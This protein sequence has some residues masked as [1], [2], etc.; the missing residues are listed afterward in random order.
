MAKEEINH[1]TEYIKEIYKK[2]NP[3]ENVL[4]PENISIEQKPKKSKKLFKAFLIFL[5]ITVIGISSF[6]GFGLAVFS[7]FMLF[8][9]LLTLMPGDKFL[10]PT[11]VL[12]L[13]EDSAGY[14][15]RSDTIMVAHIDPKHNTIGVISIPRDSRVFIPGH[16]EDKVNHAFAFG[17]IE[18][19]KQTIEQFLGIKIPYYIVIDI[20]GLRN[21]I[22]DLGGITIN[23]EKR[24]YYIDYS[25]NLFVDL[26]PGAQ[27]LSGK[28]ALAYVRY[29]SDGGDLHRIGRQQK[30]LRA[31][32][33]Q[34]TAHDNVLKS[35]QKVLK[36][37]GYLQTNLSTRQIMGLALNMKKIYDYGQ[38]KMTSLSGNDQMIG[39]IYYIQPDPSKIKETVDLYLK[40]N[41]SMEA[42]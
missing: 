37:L 8:E 3:K 22:D 4:N 5:I 11:N 30:F 27:K 41:I 10:G 15:R 24:M 19:S 40:D 36:L 42:F 34:I 12:V 2:H 16:G 20:A 6:L 13:G 21:F 35:S 28:D 32:A 7:R 39:G 14:V 1:E 18:L 9:A 25:Q 17:G 29:R 33:E 26:K 38:I 31:L 23:V